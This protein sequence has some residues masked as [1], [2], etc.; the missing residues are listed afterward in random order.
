MDV[1]QYLIR[2]SFIADAGHRLFFAD[3]SQQEMYVM[4]DQAGELSVIEKLLSGE[5]QDFYL[6]TSAVLKDVLGVDITRAEAKAM[7]LG[8]AYGQGK[9]LLGKNLNKTP[10]EAAEFKYKFFQALPKL[11]RLSA[12]LQ[13]Q[14]RW[15]GK[16]HNPF[17]R[18]LYFDENESYKA[19]NG[20]VQG[21]S[22]DITKKA[23]VDV[24]RYFNEA[25]LKSKLSLCVHDELIFNILLGEEEKA[26]PLINKAMVEAYPHKHIKL[27]VDFEYSEINSHGVSPWGEKVDY[28]R[29]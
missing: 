27:K 18:V 15:H 4:L 12:R 20:F 3:Y 23:M 14:V 25:G 17:G 16:I 6:A 11:K 19:L 13:N 24:F 9:D 8:L 21:T 22:A 1:K 28:E 2:N 5:F 29:N 7:A 10:D 26:L